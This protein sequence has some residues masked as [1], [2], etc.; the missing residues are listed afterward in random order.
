M[1]YILTLKTN[2]NSTTIISFMPMRILILFIKIESYKL[3][4]NLQQ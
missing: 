3:F 2:R 1:V 4:S